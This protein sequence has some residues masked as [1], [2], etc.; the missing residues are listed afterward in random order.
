[1]DKFVASTMV[2]VV[3]IE[4]DGV[5]QPRPQVFLDIA[6]VMASCGQ[7]VSLLAFETPNDVTDGL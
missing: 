6:A 7:L 1:M 5:K 3:G 4:G 2:Y